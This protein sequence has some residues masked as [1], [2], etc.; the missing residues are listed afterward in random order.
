[1]HLSNQLDIDVDW[2]CIFCLMIFNSP[3]IFRFGFKT[4]RDKQLIRNFSRYL[5][6]KNFWIIMPC[7]HGIFRVFAKLNYRK[8]IHNIFKFFFE[9]SKSFTKNISINSRCRYPSRRNTDS[10]QKQSRN[11]SSSKLEKYFLIK[12]GNKTSTRK[13]F[14]YAFTLFCFQW[15]LRKYSFGDAKTKGLSSVPHFEK[16]RYAQSACTNV[17]VPL[18]TYIILSPLNKGKII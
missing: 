18:R 1:M 7:R 12:I 6:V 10:T 16:Y 4:N 2:V 5:L 3:N 17:H 11:F 9:K 14:P 13:H 8:I 15:P